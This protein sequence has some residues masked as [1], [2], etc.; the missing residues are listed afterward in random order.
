[1]LVHGTSVDIQ[2]VILMKVGSLSPFMPHFLIKDIGTVLPWLN[3]SYH[4]IAGLCPGLFVTRL[5][6][7]LSVRI[8]I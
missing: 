2:F 3:M 1:M 7:F 8:A 4:T 6:H 5:T